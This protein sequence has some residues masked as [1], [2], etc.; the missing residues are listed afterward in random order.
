MSG[1]S[2]QKLELPTQEQL[3]YLWDEYKYRHGLCWKAVYMII[4]RN[5]E[6]RE[7]PNPS[8]QPAR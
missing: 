6:F 2:N 8:I 3:S 1:V 4:D 7:Q 5:D